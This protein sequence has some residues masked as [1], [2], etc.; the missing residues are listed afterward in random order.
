[1]LLMLINTNV[2]PSALSYTC[3]NGLLYKKVIELLNKML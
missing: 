2:N 3:K 1:M